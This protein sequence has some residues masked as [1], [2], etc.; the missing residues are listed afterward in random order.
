MRLLRPPWGRDRRRQVGGP[1]PHDQAIL[2]A[3]CAPE[4]RWQFS[5]CHDLEVSG[6]RGQ[7]GHSTPGFLKGEKILRGDLPD[8][9]ESDWIAM[10]EEIRAGA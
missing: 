5:A 4:T 7:V 1:G 9:N 6:S 3:V 8:S 2:Q 10:S